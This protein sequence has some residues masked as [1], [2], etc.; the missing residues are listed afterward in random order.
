MANFSGAAE[1][2]GMNAY[3][4]TASCMLMQSHFSSHIQQFIFVADIHRGFTSDKHHYRIIGGSL[5]F[6]I[7]FWRRPQG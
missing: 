2:R 3:F 1:R 4:W 7:H 6:A 5:Y